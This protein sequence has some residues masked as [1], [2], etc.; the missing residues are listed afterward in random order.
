MDIVGFVEIVVVS[1]CVGAWI[2]YEVMRGEEKKGRKRA[3][4]MT[5][6][7]ILEVG[8]LDKDGAVAKAPPYLCQAVEDD[9]V[10]EL[11]LAKPYGE[12][13]PY[14]AARAAG[15]V[16]ACMEIRAKWEEL[17]DRSMAERMRREKEREKK[18]GVV[19]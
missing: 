14:A 11:A 10:S 16:A 12:G 2:A 1:G 3:E 13:Y 4:G 18:V 7:E 8:T 6:A 17:L 19:G 15:K 9:A 5:L